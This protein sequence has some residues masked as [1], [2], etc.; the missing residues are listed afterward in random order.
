MNWT[1]KDLIVKKKGDDKTNIESNEHSKLPIPHAGKTSE[2]K[3][4]KL[5]K[6]VNSMMN[7]E[8]TRF[9]MKTILDKRREE[10]ESKYQLTN[11][12][13]SGFNF[14]FAKAEDKAVD[15]S[16]PFYVPSG[17]PETQVSPY[18]Y[19]PIIETKEQ[20]RNH[21]EEE[22]NQKLSKIDGENMLESVLDEFSHLISKK[23]SDSDKKKT[24]TIES[25]KK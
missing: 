3:V 10:S 8:E 14:N 17:E 13:L 21:L 15:F 11:C 9:E 5:K 12:N 4:N 20:I 23:Q 19:Q 1:I 24:T 18:V 22:I 25:I 16:K 2:K 7:N 6:V